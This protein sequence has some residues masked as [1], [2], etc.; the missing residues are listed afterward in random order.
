VR[1][2]SNLS[3]AF[4]ILGDFDA[5]DAH[6][7]EGISVLEK[8]PTHVSLPEF[9]RVRARVALERQRL[10]QALDF[11]ERA[12]QSVVQV[13]GPRNYRAATI[14]MTRGEILTAMGRFE[15]ARTALDESI[16]LFKEFELDPDHPDIMSARLAIASAELGQQRNESAESMA[17]EIVAEVSKLPQR[18]RYWA[19]EAAANAQLAAVRI[20]TGNPRASCDP[21]AA[22]IRL[23]E[24]HSSSSDSR[25]DRTRELRKN[26]CID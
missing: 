2:H 17:L 10:P 20:S 6:A 25:L 19:V 22:S 11:I 5:A 8:T 3:G 4:L 9:L 14:L 1:V 12:W 15:D 18:E 13:R 26:Y 24:A 23:R 16:A 21:L 7:S